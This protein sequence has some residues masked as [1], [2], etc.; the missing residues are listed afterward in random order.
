MVKL[1]F[2]RHLSSVLEM[3]RTRE[4]PMARSFGAPLFVVVLSHL[5]IGLWD[6]Y[7]VPLSQF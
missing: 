7:I 2:L 5:S 4:R 6:A 1:Y 3:R